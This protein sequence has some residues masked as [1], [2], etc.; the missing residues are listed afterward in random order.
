MK[1]HFK[2]GEYKHVILKDDTVIDV[3]CDKAHWVKNHV[4]LILASLTE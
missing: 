4:T 3:V 2:V 1:L